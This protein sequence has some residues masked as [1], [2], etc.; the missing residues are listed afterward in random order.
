MSNGIFVIGTDTDVGKTLISASLGWKLSKGIKKVCIMKP[1]ATGPEIYSKSFKS[2]DVSKLVN[3]IN[4][5][6]F[7]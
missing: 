5:I 7:N 4:L 1:F 2:E 6:Y 3:S